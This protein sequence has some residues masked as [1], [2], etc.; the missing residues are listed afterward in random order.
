[1]YFIYH[2]Q[3]QNI[4]MPILEKDIEKSILQYLNLLPGCLAWKNTTAGIYDTRKKVFRTNK[5]TLKGVSD[6]I[7][8][9]NKKVA[10]I[11]VKSKKGKLSDHQKNFIGTCSRLGVKAFVA[12]SVQDVIDNLEDK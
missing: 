3:S 4:T 8:I 9:Y 7:C 5:K 12:R 2:H 11:E 6:I 10:F 1:M